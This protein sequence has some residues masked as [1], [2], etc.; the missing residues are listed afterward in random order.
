MVNLTDQQAYLAMFRFLD[1]CRQLGFEKIG[2]L[3]GSLSLLPDGQPADQALATDW[4]AAVRDVVNGRVDAQ[5]KL[6]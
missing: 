6:S 4:A 1:R 3:L 2:S 5:M